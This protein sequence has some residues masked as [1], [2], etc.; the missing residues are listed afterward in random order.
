MSA[1]PFPIVEIDGV[2]ERDEPIGS[3]AKFWFRREAGGDLWLFKE[4]RPNTGE[5]WAEKLAAEFAAMLGL[6]HAEVEL[7]RHGDIAG[8]V[9]K[10]FTDQHRLGVLVHGNELLFEIDREYPKER[11]FHVR[12]H[13]LSAVRRVLCSGAVVLPP[14]SWPSA[15]KTPW[16]GFIGYLVLD[17]LIGNTDRHHQN[18]G[19]LV[20]GDDATQVR[21]LAPT[22]DHASSLG[23]ELIDADRDH[24]LSTRDSR[25]NVSA[26]VARARSAFHD[27]AGQGLTTE[28]ALSVAGASSPA[29]LRAWLEQLSAVTPDVCDRFIAR[30]P[31]PRMSDLARRFALAFLNETR[32]R[33]QALIV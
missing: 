18:W 2:P 26:Y 28:A 5:D 7:A 27:D 30:V 19:V 16:D 17:A 3:K 9:I 21:V 29:A 32:T 11:F 14:A 10:D 24:R 12:E 23:R 6:P 25:G 20:R 31:G 13:T 33:L 4:A 15:V 1:D 8:V 22:F